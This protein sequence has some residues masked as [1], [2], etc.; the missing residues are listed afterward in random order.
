[1]NESADLRGGMAAAPVRARLQ[2]RERVAVAFDVETRDAA[3]RLREKL[4]DALGLAKVGSA[5]FVREGMPLVAAL[6]SSGVSVFLDLKFHDI[7]S[8]VGAAV[9]KATAQGVDYLTVH[10]AGGGAMIAAAA[11]AV[12]EAGGR[13]AAGAPRTKVLAVTV[14]T[15]LDLDA[16]RAGASPSEASV[17]GAVRRLASLAIEAGAAG[18]VGS[19]RETAVLRE[20]G[21]AGAILVTPGIT[22]GAGAAAADQARTMTVKDALRSGTDILVV[23]RGVVAAADPRRALEDVV[24]EIEAAG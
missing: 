9:E 11:R 21:G 18:L 12:R 22:T 19:A 15:S 5:L 16:W 2:P 14:L 7:P 6:Q 13:D 17:E 10:A 20:A 4:G 1:M 8:V 3:M 24:R 23:G